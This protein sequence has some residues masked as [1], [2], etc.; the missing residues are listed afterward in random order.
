MITYQ[1]LDESETLLINGTSGGVKHKQG[2]DGL[3]SGGGTYHRTQE[4]PRSGSTTWCEILQSAARLLIAD[5]RTPTNGYFSIMPYFQTY[6]YQMRMIYSTSLYLLVKI[7]KSVL[8]CLSHLP[9]KHV[10]YLFL[11][12]K[13]SLQYDWLGKGKVKCA[14]SSGVVR[15]LYWTEFKTFD[16]QF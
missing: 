15:L 8:Y 9:C 14:T 12:V 7:D 2:D 1:C 3:A 5:S 13:H 6:M 10:A 16:V 11:R 4:F